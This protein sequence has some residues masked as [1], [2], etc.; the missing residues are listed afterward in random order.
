MVAPPR[1]QRLSLLA[2]AR[3]AEGAA[4]V[5]DVLRAFT[6]VTLSCRKH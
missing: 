5:I 3:K 2:G 1:I 4:I 6:L